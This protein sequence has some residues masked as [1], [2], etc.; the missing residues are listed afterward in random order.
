MDPRQFQTK[1][2][3]FNEAEPRTIP[4]RKL[5]LKT[6]PTFRNHSAHA[7]LFIS[8]S[9]WGGGP[10]AMAMA[11]AVLGILC[12][13]TALVIVLFFTT[14]PVLMDGYSYNDYHISVLSIISLETG[15]T[16]KE[17]QLRI[18]IGW[19]PADGRPW[20][21]SRST[22]MAFFKEFLPLLSVLSKQHILCLY[23]LAL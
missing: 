6:K 16:A 22:V 20:Y 3:V 15:C 7:Y 2:V 9:L 21:S 12:P 14:H 23:S 17:M 1:T 11:K 18:S 10:M 19:W 8:P 5:I 13:L 4:K